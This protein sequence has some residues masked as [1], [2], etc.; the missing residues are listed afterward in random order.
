VNR[1]GD[2]PDAN[3]AN[4]VCDVEASTAGN[5]CTLRA[6]IQESNDTTGADTI[7][8]N[9]PGTGVK[10]ISPASVLPMI[11]KPVTIDGYTQQ[12]AK[13]NNHAVGDNAVL[14]I[15][16]RGPNAEHGL[17]IGA[18]NS[19]I[20]GLAI[21]RWGEGIRIAGPGAN[22][23]RVV[24][25]F[26]GTNASGTQDLGNGIGGVRISS[27]PDNTIGGLVTQGSN[28]RNVISG[29]G[30]RGVLITGVM[31]A[32]NEV[33]GNYIG[34]DA[35]GTHRLRNSIGV[36]LSETSLNVI[37]GPVTATSNPGNR[38]SGNSSGGVVIEGAA[39]TGNFILSNSIE[40]N[41]GL[42]INLVGGTE[43]SSGVTENDEDDTDSGPNNLQNS[44]V[45]TSAQSSS[46]D[47]TI[48][49]TLSSTAETG[50][51]LQF[52]SSPTADPSGFGEGKKF[53]FEKNV[54]TEPT[55]VASFTFKTKKRVPK[56]QV[57]TATAMNGSLEHFGDTSE[58]SN[59]VEVN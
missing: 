39:A 15:V 51:T 33:V 18:A 20:K 34:T 54:V 55:G 46:V 43:D 45:L 13:P 26:I 41:G 49:G 9:I 16:L 24:G 58:F 31:A 42:G 7:T 12:G 32:R 56:G 48:K 47:S 50:F 4:A 30:D 38:I 23:N 57:V 17:Q 29:N 21:N 11:T 28:P 53:R 35:S 3:L 19:T 36:L 27:A 22:G 52:F 40:A 6:A 10:S 59:A 37:G 44:P 5:Q 14:R 8:F 25:N 1:T 2:S